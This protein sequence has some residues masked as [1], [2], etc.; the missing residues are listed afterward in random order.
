MTKIANKD[1]AMSSPFS[2][3]T[4]LLIFLETK[5]LNDMYIFIFCHALLDLKTGGFPKNKI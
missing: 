4:I 1:E 3:Y 5:N 2:S